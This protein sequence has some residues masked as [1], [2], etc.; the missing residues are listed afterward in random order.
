[1]YFSRVTISNALTASQELVELQK[2]GAYASHALLWQLFPGYEDSWSNLKGK[3]K[4]QA[5][6]PFLFR[7]EIDSNGLPL[8]YVLSEQQPVAAHPAFACQTKPYQPRLSAGDRL[9]FKLR[10]N[11]VV[12]IRDEQGK[13][14]RHDVLMNAKKNTDVSGLNI[15]EAQQKQALAAH[16]A[17]LGWI[18]DSKRLADWGIQLESEPEIDHDSYYQHQH[19]QPKGKRTIRYSTVD[20]QG[21]LTIVDPER[22]LQTLAKGVGKAKGFGCGLWLIRRCQ[23]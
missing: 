4:E 18:S 23:E 2:N 19:Y 13:S 7:E 1:M 6:R 10:V 11:P 17:A 20:Y 12:S 21:L 16:Q 22:F 9:A 14:R 8:F 15:H 3:A 5:Q